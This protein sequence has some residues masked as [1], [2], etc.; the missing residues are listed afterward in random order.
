M[1]EGERRAPAAPAVPPPRGP[2]APPA[3]PPLPGA[4][5][6]RSPAGS[7]DA[8]M[9]GNR[10]FLLIFLTS[11]IER[12]PAH[13]LSCQLLDVLTGRD[14]NFLERQAVGHR[15]LRAAQPADRRV[16]VV[17]AALLHAGCD[18]GGHAV[19]R[20]ALPPHQPPRPTAAPPDDLRTTPGA[21]PTAPRA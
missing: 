12:L 4:P 7:A 19:R 3:R 17:E 14:R 1:G 21:G 8:A 15:H 6:P 11:D 18:L 2:P 5:A 10:R 20:P 16:E 9:R 13:D